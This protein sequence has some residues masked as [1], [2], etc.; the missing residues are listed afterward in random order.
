MDEA[1]ALADEQGLA[2]LTI[3]SLATRLGAKPMAIYHHVPNKD[4][5]LDAVVD[6]VFGEIELP[7]P[8]HSWRPELRRRAVSARAVLRRHAWSIGL[9]DSRTSAPRPA[10][11][12]H[13]DAV[14]GTLRADGFGVAQTAHA[15]ALLDSYVY[16]FVLQE[17]ALPAT[18]PAEIPDEVAEMTAELDTGEYPHLAELAREHFLQ[19]GYDFA[20]EFDLGLEQVLDALERLRSA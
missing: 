10:T 4:A 16:G 12:R 1:L 13:H 18:Q 6:R 19:P 8:G 11:L 7:Q 20:D 2:A 14:I 17:V 3:R 5:I 15:F 9:L